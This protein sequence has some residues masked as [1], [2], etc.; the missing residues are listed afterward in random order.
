MMSSVFDIFTTFC[1][2][3]LAIIRAQVYKI[4][5]P[6]VKNGKTHFPQVWDILKTLF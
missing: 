5:L 6:G 1:V 4:S 3:N 2:V